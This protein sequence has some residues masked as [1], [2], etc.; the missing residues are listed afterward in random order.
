M[1]QV[2]TQVD[3]IFIFIVVISIFFLLLITGAMIY[4]V[5]RYRA[6]RHPNAENITGNTT[7][8]VVWT[9][10]PLILV[11]AMFFYGLEGFNN[12]RNVPPDALVV[13]VTG[14]MWVWNYEYKNGKKSDTLYV[15]LGK[16]IKLELES[17]DVI[18]SFYIPAYRV[19]EDAV[20]GRTN[21]M[22]FNPTQ[23]GMYDV[24]CAEYCGINHSYMLSKVV[25]LKEEEFEDWS[26]R[27]PVTE[28]T[29][30]IKVQPSKMDT[31]K[32]SGVKQD[33]LKKDTTKI[34]DTLSRKNPN[35]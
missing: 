4:F 2:A 18:H 32:T 31:L 17:V 13:K 34:L 24:F 23:L 5:V 19:K 27:I 25:V 21:Y 3:N 11:M 7:L 28:K 35:K 22:W 16:P 26:K 8:E 6:V 14:R 30:T 29:D 1:N 10:V 20:P 15:P 33:T 9:V 12:M